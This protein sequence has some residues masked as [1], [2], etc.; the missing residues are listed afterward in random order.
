MKKNN[1]F[2]DLCAIFT[3]LGIVIWNIIAIYYLI[4]SQTIPYLASY[5]VASFLLAMVCLVIAIIILV[6]RLVQKRKLEKG[7][8]KQ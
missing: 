7:E 1:I 6:I 2:F 5:G 3:I 8:K 4:T